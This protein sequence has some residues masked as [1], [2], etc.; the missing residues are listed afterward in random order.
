[1]QSTC[2]KRAWKELPQRW[3]LQRGDLWVFYGRL[4][5]VLILLK[6]QKKENK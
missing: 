1:M 5:S 4:I 6:Y 2:R 3:I